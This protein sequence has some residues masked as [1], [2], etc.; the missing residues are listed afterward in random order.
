MP[1]RGKVNIAI[2][3][4]E[5]PDVSG[6]QEFLP[7]YQEQMGRIEEWSRFVSNGQMEYVVHFP[8]RWIMAPKEAKFYTNPNSRN[9]PNSQNKIAS[10]GEEFQ[11]VEESI[12]QIIRAAD[13]YID[14]SIIDFVQFIFPYDTEQYGT[15]LYSHGGDF[16]T[17]K[18][19]SVN[20][21][22]YGETVLEFNPFAPNPR[23][24][25]HWDWIVHEILHFQGIISG[26]SQFLTFPLLPQKMMLA[27]K[28]TQK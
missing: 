8:N 2:V 1:I 19:G 25:T 12:N 7:I 20:F 23:N 28:V 16:S 22:V 10:A 17:P 5:F 6:E 4:V 21:P 9:S 13:D 18:A 3:A 26:L 15:F 27:S 24:R 14:W 11:S